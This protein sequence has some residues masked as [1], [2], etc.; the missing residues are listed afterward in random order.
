M[1]C[2]DPFQTATEANTIEAYEA[3]LE[4]NPD[5][6]WRS[7][8]EL[9]VEDLY[10]ERAREQKSL[11]GFD[12]YLEKFPKGV[13]RDTVMEERRQLAFDQ[14]DQVDTPE[15]W[16]SF[17]DEYPTGNKKMKQEAQRRQAMAHYGDQVEIG[18]VSMERVNMAEDPEGPK[19]GWG[20]SAEV[21]NKGDKNVTRLDLRI[22]YL[23]ASGKPVEDDIWPVVAPHL[24]GYLPMTEGFDLPV[25]P[26]QVRTWEWSTSDLEEVEWAE[27][28]ELKPVRVA[29]VG[30]AEEK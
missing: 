15:A 19:N 3:F 28:V 11:A 9:R 17:L 30:A 21:T 10:L 12:T 4:A 14:A 18:P 8:A 6:P 27:K 29:F 13:H 26:G 25:G 24:P 16:Q 7:Q 5:S 1:A 20:F 2:D 23:D 22:R